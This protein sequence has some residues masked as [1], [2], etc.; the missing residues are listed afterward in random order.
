MVTVESIASDTVPDVPPPERPV[1]AVTPVI[2]PTSGVNHSKVPFASEVLNACPLE[3]T[4][5]GRVTVQEVDTVPGACKA[6][7]WPPVVS[8]NRKSPCAV[9]ST[10]VPVIAAGVVPPITELS[11]VP[12]LI[13]RSSATYASA[14][15]VPCHVP[16]VIVPTVPSELADVTLFSVSRADSK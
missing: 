10:C 3:P 11:T 8:C 9:I 5:A 7:Y 15:A 14:T 1:P 12:P 4:A 13:V 6:T 2:S 16:E